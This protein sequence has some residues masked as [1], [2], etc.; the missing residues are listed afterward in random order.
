MNIYERMEKENT[1]GHIKEVDELAM[2][3][4]EKE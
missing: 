2:I 3:T 4:A 1:V